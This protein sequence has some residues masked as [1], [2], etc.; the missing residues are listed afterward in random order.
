MRVN[1]FGF[2]AIVVLAL[3]MQ[4]PA[5][6]IGLDDPLAPTTAA[7]NGG[8]SAET[9]TTCQAKAPSD[10]PVWERSLPIT[11]VPSNLAATDASCATEIAPALA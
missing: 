2:V 3:V 7:A 9:T 5:R 10:P 4:V 8:V 1:R 6:A 11:Q